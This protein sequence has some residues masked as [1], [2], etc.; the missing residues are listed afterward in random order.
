MF[1]MPNLGTPTF[2]MMPQIFLQPQ[3][4]P[5]FTYGILQPQV[6]TFITQPTTMA[7][8][9]QQPMTASTAQMNEEVTILSSSPQEESVKQKVDILQRAMI[10]ISNEDEQDK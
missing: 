5:L 7:T 6:Q 3:P 9:S 8:A 4:Q 10:E 2:T 1:L